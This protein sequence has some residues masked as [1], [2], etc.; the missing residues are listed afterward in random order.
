MAAVCCVLYLSL[1]VLTVSP[2]NWR[3]CSEKGAFTETGGGCGGVSVKIE[4]HWRCLE[5]EVEPARGPLA[6]CS[7][8]RYQWSVVKATLV[9]TL[10][11]QSE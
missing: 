8:L 7:Q 11:C 10:A 6:K 2:L 4:G 9:V 5:K 3:A 1:S